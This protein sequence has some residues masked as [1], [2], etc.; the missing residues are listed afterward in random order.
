MKPWNDWKLV[1]LACLL[2]GLAPFVPEPHLLG[3]LRW[4]AGGAV[5]MKAMDW[6]DLAWHG[7]PWVLLLRLIVLKIFTA[8]NT[9]S[10]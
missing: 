3:K 8:F 2:L 7:L 10:E 4:V 5:G 6:F 9:P 1:V